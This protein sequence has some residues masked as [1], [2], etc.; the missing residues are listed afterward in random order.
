MSLNLGIPW[1][2]PRDAQRAAY[3]AEAASQDLSVLSLHCGKRSEIP[4]PYGDLRGMQN[5]LMLVHS[6]GKTRCASHG[7]G[8]HQPGEL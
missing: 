1:V 6:K 8:S 5:A 3:L 2:F 7:L 4:L